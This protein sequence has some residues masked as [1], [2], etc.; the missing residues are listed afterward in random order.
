MVSFAKKIKPDEV[1]MFCIC[2]SSTSIILSYSKDNTVID[3]WL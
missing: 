3:L 2:E 1:S